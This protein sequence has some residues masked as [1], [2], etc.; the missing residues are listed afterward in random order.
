MINFLRKN[1]IVVVFAFTLL[2][3]FSGNV[4]NAATTPDLGT[5]ETYGVLAGTYTNVAAGTTI[6][7]GIG[8]T[9][10]P[11]TV[12]A[13]IHTSY[14]P[15]A[16]TPAARID[17]NTALGALGVQPCTFTFAAGAIDLSTDATHGPVGV[18]TPGVYC[19]TGA[20]DIG[21][22][23]T[24][25]GAGTYIFRPTG[26]L[27]STAGS[28]VTLLG[29][30]AC[31]V[32]WTPTAATTLA[33]N[34]IFAGTVIDDA[35]AIT[36]G[37][38]TVWNG[39]ALSLGAGTVTTDTNT[40]TVPTCTATLHVI[41]T[42]IND[43]TGIGVSSDATLHVTTGGID[44]AGSPQAGVDVL[45]TTYVLDPGTYAVSEDALAGY[46]VTYSGDCDAAGNIIL[47][48]ENDRTCT[49][50]N[51]D[52]APSTITVTKVVI[53]DSGRTK[54]IAD[55]PLF[56]NGAPVVS[57][58]TNTLAPAIYTVTETADPNYTQSFSGD[59]NALG[60]V[61]LNVSEARFCI[62]TNND[63]PFPPTS[64]G[65]GGY[66]PPVSTPVTTPAVPPLIDIVKT[67]SPLALPNGPGAV[68]YTYTLRN[69]GTVVVN[70]ITLVG[71]TCSPIALFS[72]D[73]NGNAILDL[74]EVWVHKCT[75]TLTETH[76]NTVVA[77]GWANNISTVDIASATVI[78]GE[79]IV[80]PSI[81]VIKIPRPLTLP[82]GG[83]WAT[84]TE[85]INNTGTVPLS[86]VT[87]TDDKCRPVRYVSGDTNKDSKLDTNERWIYTC[88]AYLRTTTT[89]T[90]IASGT[91]NGIRVR[92]IAV[93]TVVVALPV[94]GV[95]AA[96]TPVAAPVPAPIVVS[97]V[98]IPKL[99][100]TGVVPETRVLPVN[101][102]IPSIAVNAAVQKVG[103]TADGAMDIP[104]SY[105]DA[106]WY[107]LGTYPGDI[108]SAVMD[109]HLNWINN[110]R[111]VFADLQK[112]KPGDKI[113]VKDEKGNIVSF[114]VRESKLYGASDDAAAIFSSSD[115]K[116]HLNLITCDGVWDKK[117]Q[118]YS[119]RLVVFADKE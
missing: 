23:L 33:A 97:P 59:C 1:T 117:Q 92:D 68:E 63:I 87:L 39:R 102:I 80:A 50:T 17:V 119:K 15:G 108:G 78:V 54:V 2:F 110:V 35:T 91:G 66:T 19:S 56:I 26:A 60:I 43:N 14:G 111:G 55:F 85:I 98:I 61:T 105:S 112:L 100:K 46:T 32:F 4:A 37:A 31:D 65:G 7:G 38:N 83:G 81:H 9:T 75:T 25:S 11:A 52:I 24:L 107:E 72:G 67:P 73:T 21:G 71:D 34:T 8:F 113:L 76:T 13:G 94:P 42:V 101:I 84:Y 29:A 114:I 95:P 96:I 53:N 57:G 64:G 6:D 106:G 70:N 89:N 48:S 86:N 118:Q 62:I 12:P 3:G 99:P 45:G 41:K 109:G 28:V 5:G 10:P 16:P 22:P 69:I 51:N 74:T 90:A 20:M 77:T 18:Y 82:S 103:L 104:K 115:G 47:A 30:S 27:T 40:I 49:V 36:I 58:I 44:V 93:A 79:P 88:R 116:A